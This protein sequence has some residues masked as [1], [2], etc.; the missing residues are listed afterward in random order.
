MSGQEKMYCSNNSQMNKLTVL[1][2][3]FTQSTVLAAN[4]RG[5][6]NALSFMWSPGINIYS[7]AVNK[8]QFQSHSEGR[9]KNS[10][11]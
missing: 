10:F 5:D 1:W 3:F 9:Q 2:G 6:G 4:E 11:S 7:S 8:N